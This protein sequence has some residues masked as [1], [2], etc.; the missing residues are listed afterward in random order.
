MPDDDLD[1]A[2]FGSAFMAFMEATT[3][4]AAPPRSPLLDRIQAHLGAD[5]T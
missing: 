5:P 1:P 2:R 4:A 3:A